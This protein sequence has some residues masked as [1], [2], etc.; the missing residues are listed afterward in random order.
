MGERDEMK[1]P[2]AGI[3][4]RRDLLHLG[5]LGACGLTVDWLSPN[6]VLNAATAADPANFGKAK[7]CILLFLFGSPPQHETFDPKPDAPEEIRGEMGSI[8]TNV[9]GLRI[10]DGLPRTAQVMDRVTLVRSMTHPY[11]LHGVAYALTGMPTYT[12]AI[13]AQPRNAAHWPF[14]GSIVDYIERERAGG[15]FPEVPHCIGLPWLLNS[16][17]VDVP[18]LAGPYAAF[19]GSAH[20]PVWTDFEGEATTVVPKLAAEQKVEVRDHFAGVE[21]SGRFRLASTIEESELSNSRFQSRWKFLSQLDSNAGVLGR[22]REVRT[23]RQLQQAAY[24]MLRSTKIRE[25]LDIHQ[26]PISLREEYGMTLFGQSA[27]AARRLVEAGCKFVSVFWDP[28]GPF[29]GSVW[30]THAN[31]FPR[32]KDYLL[33]VFDQTYP[34]LIKDLDQRGLLDDTLVLCLSEHGRTPKISN[35]KGGGR[36]HWSRA[37][38]AVL[39]GGGVGRGNV[40]GKTDKIGGDVESTPVSPKDVLATTFHL[41]G[42]SPETLMHDTLGRPLA[43]AGSGVVR[44]ELF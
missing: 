19:L 40:V 37:Y 41:L 29:G 10:C 38:S 36:E 30:D 21:P 44:T 11:P 16:R 39:A 27:L 31:H 42:I 25:A 4:N 9:P 15:E 5:G 12:P 34:T 32:L 33:P 13:E 3:L 28:V 43:I 24:S 1:K 2:M 35:R 20:D 22:Q 14:I 6:K 17:C 23:Y 18:P 8:P 26:E 7:S